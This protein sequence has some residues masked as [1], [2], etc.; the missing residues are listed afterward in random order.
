[1]KYVQLILQRL[2]IITFLFIV[3]KAFAQYEIT[4]IKKEWLSEASAVVRITEQDVKVE[5]SGK[6]MVRD[7][8]VITILKQDANELAVLKVNYSKMTKIKSING[9]VYDALGKVILK[10]K[11]KN[12]Q[13]YSNFSS[14]SIYEDNRIQ[15]L[16]LKQFKLPYTVEFEYELELSNLYYLPNWVPQNYSQVPVALATAVYEYPPTHQLRF[17]SKNILSETEAPSPK[18]K[19][20]LTKAWKLTDI[21]KNIQEPL[22]PNEIPK[23]KILYASPSTFD[24]DGYKG[25]LSSWESI[26]NW[27]NL[28]NEGKKNLSEKTKNEVK[29]LTALYQTDR[30]KVK[31]LY[32][33][34]QNKTRYVSIQL[35]IGGL[36]PFDAQTVEKYSYG[37]CKALSNYMGALL[38]VIGIENYYTLIYGGNNPVAVIEE[39]PNSYFNHVILTVP[40]SDETIW[41]EC[42]SQTNPFGYLS[43][44]TSDRL[45]LMVTNKGGK[46]IKTPKYQ[47]KDNFQHQKVSFTLSEEGSATGNATIMMRGLQTERNQL[48]SVAEGPSHQKKTWITENLTLPSLSLLDFHITASKMKIPEVEIETNFESRNMVTKSGSRLVIQPNILN[49]FSL[50]LGNSKKDRFYPFQNPLAFEDLDEI[51]FKLP[52][53]FS[54]DHLPEGIS[55][56]SDFGVYKADYGFTDGIFTYR[57]HLHLFE[58]IFDASRFEDYKQFLKEI[59][60]ADN[61][62]VVVQKK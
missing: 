38:D 35:G 53:G 23:Y 62:K 50:G 30:E 12:L 25:D 52:L 44:F 32:E 21:E 3:P 7:K 54:P 56:S 41:L 59:E 14:F 29:A 27:F 58:G 39:F 51:E 60:Q 49:R 47:A 16:D 61:T 5:Q 11:A 26:G 4:S 19:G 24:Y 31:V 8:T 28:L 20:N 37:D 43:D 22:V 33:Y 9:T 57:R 10:S 13:D 2:T 40:L 6:V 45:G 42:T 34:M 18:I 36:Q 1:M 55:F 17:Y 46:L 15:V 48:L